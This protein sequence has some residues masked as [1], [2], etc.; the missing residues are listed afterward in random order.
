MDS[1]ALSLRTSDVAQLRVLGINAVDDEYDFD[2]D[3]HSVSCSDDGSIGD[4][5]D[6]DTL[7]EDV[8]V[9]DCVFGVTGISDDV[10]LG[11]AVLMQS[12]GIMPKQWIQEARDA[13]PEKLLRIAE[14]R[15]GELSQAEAEGFLRRA[16]QLFSAVGLPGLQV[17]R[18]AMLRNSDV[19]D[20][21]DVDLWQAWRP[22]GIESVPHSRDATTATTEAATATADTTAASLP[23]AD[24]TAGAAATVTPVDEG[25]PARLKKLRAERSMESVASTELLRVGNAT[26]SCLLS[27]GG[28]ELCN[29][30]PVVAQC[31]VQCR[32]T[33]VTANYD[34][35][36]CASFA[37]PEFM[38]L[39]Q[40][41]GWPILKGGRKV[42]L[43]DG[44]PIDTPC[45]EVFVLISLKSPLTEEVHS[46]EVLLGELQ[47]FGGVSVTL[48]RECTVELHLDEWLSAKVAALRKKRKRLQT[49]VRAKKLSRASDAVLNKIIGAVD[50]D[51]E[52]GRRASGH[53]GDRHPLG[54]DKDKPPDTKKL[55]QLREEMRQAL[56]N[57]VEFLTFE[58]MGDDFEVAKETS[59][60]V[61]GPLI[62]GGKEVPQFPNNDRGRRL[63]KEWASRYHELANPLEPGQHIT[64]VPYYVPNLRKGAQLQPQKHRPPPR[65][66]TEVER[67]LQ[68]WVDSKF[69]ERSTKPLPRAHPVHLHVVHNPD[70]SRKLRLVCVYNAPGGLNSC[71]NICSFEAKTIDMVVEMLLQSE[72]KSTV[73]LRSYYNQLLVHPDYREYLAIH[74]NGVTYLPNV[75]MFGA[76][77]AV[78]FAVS[79][80]NAHILGDLLQ[81]PGSKFGTVIDDVS[82]GSDSD[83]ECVRQFC[84]LMDRLKQHNVRIS[85]EKMRVG[86]L[87]LDTLGYKFAGDKLSLSNKR[88]QG[89]RVL[90]CPKTPDTARTFIGLVNFL[91]KYVPGLSLLLKS[92]QELACFAKGRGKNR[93]LPRSAETAEIDYDS[94]EKAF[95][96]ITA[97]LLEKPFLCAV[98][99]DQPI[100]V[101]TDAS[102]YGAGGFLFQMIADSQGKPQLRPVSF[103]SHRWS[104]AQSLRLHIV[105]L[106]VLASYL[107]VVRHRDILALNP[108]YLCTD[109]RNFAIAKSSTNQM[110]QRAIIGLESIGPAPV[111]IHIPG[112]ANV[113]SDACS[114][115]CAVRPRASHGTVR[116]RA[117]ARWKRSRV[118][119]A[120]H[121]PLLDQHHRKGGAHV[122]AQA[123]LD[124]LKESGH[125]WPNLAADCEW[126]VRMCKVCQAVRTPMLPKQSVKSLITIMEPFSRVQLDVWH[127]GVKSDRGFSYVLVCVDV[128]SLAV[129][130]YPLKRLTV[131]EMVPCW[132]ELLCS[133]GGLVET[134]WTDDA[135]A[136]RSKITEGIMEA[137]RLNHRL[138]LPKH[139]NANG[140]AEHECYETCRVMRNLLMENRKLNKTQ[141]C[142]FLPLVE[143][144]RNS[145]PRLAR[146]GLTPRKLLFPLSDRTA[147]QFDSTV[148]PSSAYVKRLYD[149]QN[150]LIEVTRCAL[151]EWID[152]RLKSIKSAEVTSRM[153]YEK[154]DYVLVKDKKRFGGDKL[155]RPFKGPYE[156]I[157]HGTTSDS[158][159]L[160]EVLTGKESEEHRDELKLFYFRS[161][162]DLVPMSMMGTEFVNVSRI[163]SHT[164][165]SK[166]GGDAYRFRVQ[167]EESEC[168]TFECT[169]EDVN[170]SNAYIQYRRQHPE[171]GLPEST[172]APVEGPW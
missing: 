162:D 147:E 15:A 82:F 168:D 72:I 121:Q 18:E 119:A 94:I 84:E 98:R 136:F 87:V 26:V 40:Q 2:G 131:K 30:E 150:K 54:P 103:W 24:A 27:R 127:P 101:S 110:I 61:P 38:D 93:A 1:S 129:K 95:D 81:R 137:C 104:A 167:S 133:F 141:W 70:G 43:A 73:D 34:N 19:L 68:Q 32:E 117:I 139:H 115:L 169:W 140:Y 171:Y 35:G 53:K 64:N 10:D 47:L 170:R 56:R 13:G 120:E 164:G 42:G 23:A 51:A 152:R 105:E 122:G 69:V 75:L 134:F 135:A 123:T 118:I 36:S 108:Y 63:Y 160:F 111:R 39:L 44:T 17:D 7:D 20:Q 29:N 5:Q 92:T 79:V 37:S 31:A 126:W 62:V 157:G 89:L 65:N 128:F 155:E 3:V 153:V 22:S 83:D 55:S 166:T 130:L 144:I 106:E 90:K 158:Y 116:E 33:Q 9:E 46:T 148:V 41:Q 159:Q 146:A 12:G 112:S 107:C 91:Q 4:E 154:G 14:Q 45:R 16:G 48:G 11:D 124:S 138:V 80:L 172:Q 143:W 58:N 60:T 114:R 52:G 113:P 100:Y 142:T 59:N 149:T 78:P 97:W 6:W 49:S 57:G 151:A 67:I 50:D 66:F 161:M 132:L 85:F 165:S 25:L 145:T 74:F 86:F 125:Y 88:L 28:Y 109:C 96:I 21:R 99:Y 156:V 163:I 8:M 77:D 71:L 76:A 102:R